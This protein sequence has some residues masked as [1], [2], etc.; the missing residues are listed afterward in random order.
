MKEN[1]N[2]KNNNN[3]CGNTNNVVLNPDFVTGL[4]DAEGCFSVVTR[5]DKR[6]KFEKN[7]GL[8]FKI[9]MLQNE[10]EL[11]EIVKV[12]F[13]IVVLYISVKMVLW[14]LLYKI[15]L[16]LKIKLYHIF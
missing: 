7:V 14:L 5:K 9:R 12:F 8:R 16:L 10:T 13:L 2:N 1:K 15:F 4:T 11:L 6:A 3:K